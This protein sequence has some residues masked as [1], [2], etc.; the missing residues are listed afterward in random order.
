MDLFDAMK[1]R[2]SYRGPFQ[3]KPV[4]Q[5][6]LKKIVNAALLAPSGKNCQTTQFII[7]DDEGL[8]SEIQKLHPKNFAMQQAK[9]YIVCLIDA[10]PEKV[11]E[12][13]SFEVED[14]AAAVQNMLLAITAL[15]YATVWVDGWLRYNDHAAKIAEILNIPDSKI[16]RIILPVGVPEKEKSQPEKMPFER[17]AWFNQYNG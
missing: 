17:R 15:G 1:K 4:P 6:D 9:A 8:V 12:G 11:Y 2:H 10:K 5:V 13:Y 14:C 16:V 3:D 7:V